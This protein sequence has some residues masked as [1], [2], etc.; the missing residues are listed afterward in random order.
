MLKTAALFLVPLALSAQENA[1][2]LFRNANALAAAGNY[3][4]AEP[5][6]TRALALEDAAPGPDHPLLVPILD[7]LG[8]VQ[9]AEGHDADAQA[10]YLRA[11][12]VLEKSAGDRSVTLISHLKLLAGAYAAL[13]RPIDAEQQL[14]RAI[15]IREKDESLKDLDLAADCA[16][17]GSFYLSQKRFAVAEPNFRRAIG[18][19]ERKLGP[20]TR[21]WCRS[22]I[23][24]P[25]SSSSNR[26]G[27]PPSPRCA[28]SYGSRSAR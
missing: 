13:G 3:P 7:A 21:L 15:A 19:V 16:E 6:L 22:S 26:I 8:S 5:L 24:S 28:A 20:K 2:Q 12:T 1:G 9:R 18:I 25:M 4:Q 11:L 14:L 27:R 23:T 10:S 17:L